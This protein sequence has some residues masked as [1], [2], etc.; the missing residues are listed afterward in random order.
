YVNITGHDTDIDFGT[1]ARLTPY[2]KHYAFHRWQHFYLWPLYGFMVLRWHLF[3]DFRD[4]IAGTIGAGGPR[5]PR[6]KGWELAL[7]WGGKAFFFTFAFVLP[8]LFHPVWVVALC[9]VIAASVMGILM[10]VVFE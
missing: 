6:P 10:S 1:M 2:Q 9:Y 3:G 4:V 7:F 5:F 8:M